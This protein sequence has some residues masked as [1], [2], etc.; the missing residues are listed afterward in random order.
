MLVMGT[1]CATRFHAAQARFM[2]PQYVITRHFYEETPQKVA[3]LPFA[4]RSEK[5]IDARK[6]ENCRRVFYQHLCLREFEDVE[7]GKF[8]R[9]I[10]HSS[11]TNKE[12]M[13]QQMFS[14]IRT[15]DVVGMTTVIDLEQF[16]KTENMQYDNFAEMVR[17]ARE[18]MHADAYIIGITRDYG[19]FYAVLFSSVG[20]STRL[21]MRST[22]TGSL[23][24]RGQKKK[25]N[26]E[27]PLTIN[28]LDIP[29]L[30]Y[31]VWQNSRGLAMESLT[32]RVYGDLTS[33]MPYMREKKTIFVK[34]EKDRTPC[35]DWP[36]V[37]LLGPVYKTDKGTIYE[38]RFEQNGWFNCRNHE[39]DIVWIFRDYV[40]LVDQ[41]G[42]PVQPFADLAW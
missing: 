16:Y 27:V 25:R 37:W 11:N 29:R 20:V 21:E 14:L 39:G 9:T 17:M 22:R 35:F 40:S 41:D 36:T 42:L 5:S 31:D 30:L 28:P 2:E 32:Y 18:D 13:L 26:Y 6:A 15:L 1:G 23:M 38:Y 19:R 8:D 34:V 12:S 10:G 4:T 7:L 3:V 24:W 33:T